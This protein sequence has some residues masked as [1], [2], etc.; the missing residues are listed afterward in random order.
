MALAIASKMKI[1]TSLSDIPYAIT[2]HKTLAELGWNAIGTRDDDGWL[3]EGTI[4][5]LINKYKQAI[6]L[7]I[8]MILF[9]IIYLKN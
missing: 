5:Y 9:K 3:N 1:K 7:I 4:R 2:S 8:T 6:F